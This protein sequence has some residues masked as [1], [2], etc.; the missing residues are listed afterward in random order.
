SVVL[1]I[2]GGEALYADMGHFGARPIRLTWYAVALP[3]LLL[4]YFGQGAQLLSPNPNVANPFYALVPTPLLYPMVG[5]CAM[6]TVIASQAMISGAFSLTRQAVQ[7]GYCPRVT[8]VH[9]SQSNEGQIY[10]PEVNTAIMVSCLALVVAFRES[11]KFAAAYGIAVTGSMTITSVVYYFVVTRRWGWSTWKALPL[12]AAFLVFDL[13]Y[14][15]A[16]VLKFFAGGWIPMVFATG[17]FAMMTTW[18]RGR[19]ELADRVTQS[20]VPLDI[21]LKDVGETRPHRVSG[22]AVFMSSSLEGA[23]PVLMHHLKHNKVLHEHVIL[24]SIT[25]EPVP[26]IPVLQQVQVQ[27]LEHGFY[28]VNAHFGFMQTPKV[29]DILRQCRKHGLRVD[30]ATSTFYL[31]RE[32]LL[33]GGRSRMARW[34]KGLFAFIARNARSA[35]AYFDIPPGRVVELGMQIDL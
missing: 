11:S 20:T 8:I 32:T 17:L 12:V 3:G 27:E 6:A 13:S 19:A 16:N 2:T 1:C 28:K 18:K 25:S 34:R 33:T 24:L 35:T 5:L 7:L 9:T 22:S 29:P 15:S 10:I 14:F 31:G 23:P 4:N 26:Q 30:P 21:F